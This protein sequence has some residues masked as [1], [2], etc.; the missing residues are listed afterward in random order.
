[1]KFKKRY[2]IPANLVEQM[3]L[4]ENFF[5][6]VSKIKSISNFPRMD[7]WASDQGFN[8]SFALAGYSEEDVTIS[9]YRNIIRIQSEKVEDDK[10]SPPVPKDDDAFIEY[11]KEGKAAVMSGHI[12]RGIARRSF[13]R[14]Y[15]ISE[16][17]D[18]SR[19][20]AHM[21]NGL[22]HIL[23]PFQEMNVVKNIDIETERK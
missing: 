2:S 22:L 9:A 1:M 5:E 4:D 13:D 6:K 8:M 21:E 14:S 16:E 17:F 11:S 18:A 10:Y 23:I 19:A 20:M 15:L 3:F 7:Q 12:F